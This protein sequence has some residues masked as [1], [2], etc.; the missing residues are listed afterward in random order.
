MT[1]DIKKAERC[2]L[3]AFAK[4]EKLEYDHI[5]QGS[6]TSH[7]VDSA[8]NV[9][10]SVQI[11]RSMIKE[12]VEEVDD[13]GKRVRDEHIFVA[14]VVDGIHGIGSCV[15]QAVF[16]ELPDLLE[17]FYLAYKEG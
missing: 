11:T 5:S 3:E 16:A 9:I 7:F 10:K 12:L 2:V 6:V 15:Y 14:K 4:K 1:P 8:G 17:A 13:K